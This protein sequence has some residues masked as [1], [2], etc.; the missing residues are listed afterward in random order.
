M[1]LQHPILKILLPVD[2][3][4]NSRRALQFA[5]CLGASLGKGLSGITLFHVMA[6]GYMSRHMGYIDFRAMVLTQSETF[7]RKYVD[8]KINPLL[9]E[10]ERILKDLGIKSDLVIEK[11]VAD[12]DPAMEIVRLAD[13][14]NFSTIIISRRGLSE[15]KG[16]FLG[17]VT[18]KVVHSARRQTVYIVGHNV[19]EDKTCPIP[20][21]LI[22]VDGSPYSMK[23]VEYAAS[24]AGQ[25]EAISNITLLRVIN[26]SALYGKA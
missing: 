26:P 12:G 18:S 11:Q 23:G 22:P 7:K 4:E 8:E 15:I 25:L 19:L 20:K 6:G 14:E 13:E 24:M 5:G 3:S 21:I 16:F 1:K 10:G 17:S 9:E 2:G